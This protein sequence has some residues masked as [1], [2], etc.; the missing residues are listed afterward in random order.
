MRRLFA[1]QAPVPRRPLG[2][3][4]AAWSSCS[5]PPIDSGVS[6]VVIGVG[7]RRRPMVVVRWSRHSRVVGLAISSSW[8]PP[9]SRPL[10]GPAR[11]GVLFAPQKGA[12]DDEV[13]ALEQRLTAWASGSAVTRNT[14]GGWRAGGRPMDSFDLVLVG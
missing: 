11:C 5:G 1:M 10:L 14:T 9:T 13:N 7:G 6:C 12:S 2:A 8:L 4:S 3:S